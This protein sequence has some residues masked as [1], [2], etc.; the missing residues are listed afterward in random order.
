MNFF[1]FLS[2]FQYY[3]FLNHCVFEY[4]VSTVYRKPRCAPQNATINYVCVFKHT[5]H[6]ALQGKFVDE[7]FSITRDVFFCKDTTNTH[8]ALYMYTQ[9]EKLDGV[10]KRM[11][12]LQGEDKSVVHSLELN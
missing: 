12:C 9:T 3:C 4:Q 6:H 11:Q 10:K 5:G 8:Y 1:I 7:M 2:I